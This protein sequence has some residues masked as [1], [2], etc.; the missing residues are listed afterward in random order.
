M[1]VLGH[2]R[3]FGDDGE[4][5]AHTNCGRDRVGRQTNV[6]TS[7]LEDVGQRVPVGVADD[8][9]ASV[10][11]ADQGGGKWSLKAMFQW[12]SGLRALR[13]RSGNSRDIGLGRVDGF[14]QV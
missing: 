2:E 4:R 7:R 12:P 8:V 3:R 5:S 10:S 9:A 11:S 1:S 6:E 14:S 13:S